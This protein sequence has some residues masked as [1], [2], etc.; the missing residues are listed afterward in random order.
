MEQNNEKGTIELPKVGYRFT[1]VRGGLYEVYKVEPTSRYPIWYKPVFQNGVKHPSI[2][3]AT[4]M[5]KAEQWALVSGK[6]RTE[7]LV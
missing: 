6:V 4:A 7:A 5:C 1:H 3:G 2:P